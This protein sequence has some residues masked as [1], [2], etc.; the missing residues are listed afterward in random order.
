MVTLEDSKLF[1]RLGPNEVTALRRVACEQ[2]FSAG[3]EIF[4]EG[5]AGDGVYVVKD[6]M[7]QISAG[8][9]QDVQHVF[10]Q[11]GPGDIFGEM[12]VLE[13]KPRSATAVARKE[14]AVYF[15]PRAALLD[16]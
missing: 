5:D 16:L 2:T 9:G 13:D 3:K 14:T 4:K 6:G 15:I 1:S 8:V 11:V 10:S 7:V 12:A